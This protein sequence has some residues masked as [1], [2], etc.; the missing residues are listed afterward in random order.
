MHHVSFLCLVAQSWLT[1][2]S[3]AFVGFVDTGV[4]RVILS[5]FADVGNC[6]VEVLP[7]GL[8]VGDVL[9]LATQLFVLL[10][11]CLSL[12]IDVRRKLLLVKV[13]NDTIDWVVQASLVSLSQSQRRLLVRVVGAAVLGLRCY[14]FML[15]WVSCAATNSTVLIK[16]SRA[17]GHLFHTTVSLWWHS[18]R[19]TTRDADT[20]IVIILHGGEQR[21]LLQLVVC[22][23]TVSRCFTNLRRNRLH[24]VFHD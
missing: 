19:V 4:G 2:A 10:T 21:V 9:P 23:L 20:L 22:V 24:V 16:S 14:A 13:V 15:V 3:L 1:G 8:H 11:Q 7:E 5:L 17:L 6:R 18:Y 12:V